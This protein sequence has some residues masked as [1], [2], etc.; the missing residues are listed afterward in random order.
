MEFPVPW[1]SS[2]LKEVCSWCLPYPGMLCSWGHCLSV[3]IQVH[4]FLSARLFPSSCFSLKPSC[5][6]SH[7]L[8]LL[9]HLVLALLSSWWS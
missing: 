6:S 2:V 3:L 1:W 4:Q 8:M 7:I 9:E 5:P